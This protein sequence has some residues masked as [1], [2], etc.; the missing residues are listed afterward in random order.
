[1]DTT[2]RAAYLGCLLADLLKTLDLPIKRA[3]IVLSG[4]FDGNQL[5]L[6]VGNAI[7]NCDYCYVGARDGEANV[8]G[9]AADKNKALVNIVIE[10]CLPGFLLR[11]IENDL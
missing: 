2:T 10:P 5:T 3:F 8:V 7:G 6:D 11:P 9:S 1:L 4:D